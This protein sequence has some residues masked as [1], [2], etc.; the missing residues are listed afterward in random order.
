MLE[1]Y[2]AEPEWLTTQ[3]AADRLGVSKRYV[4]QLIEQERLPA[5]KCPCGQRSWLISE[6]DIQKALI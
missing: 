2:S 1:F 5:T 3:Q 6:S 4:L